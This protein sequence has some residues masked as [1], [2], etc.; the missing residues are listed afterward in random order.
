MGADAKRKESR[1]RKFAHLQEDEATGARVGHADV[2]VENNESPLKLQK[3]GARNETVMVEDQVNHVTANEESN[4]V[5]P[6]AKIPPSEKPARFIC[7]IGTEK[8]ESSSTGKA[9]VLIESR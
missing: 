6:T 4:D 3:H 8:P 5:A 1:K 7:F 9:F 2:A